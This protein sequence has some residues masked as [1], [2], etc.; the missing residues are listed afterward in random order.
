MPKETDETLLR[1]KLNTILSYGALSQSLAPNDSISEFQIL[2]FYGDA[3]LN[4][5]VSLFLMQTRRFM[6]PG[7]LT[8]LRSECVCN[9]NLARVYDKLR[10]GELMSEECHPKPSGVKDKADVMEA[11]IGELSESATKAELH[12]YHDEIDRTISALLNF[13]SY[14][15]ERSYTLQEAVEEA[16]KE[17]GVKEVFVP[18][19]KTPPKTPHQHNNKKHETPKNNKRHPS[20]QKSQKK[21][22]REARKKQNISLDPLLNGGSQ[23]DP[24]LLEE[25]PVS[26]N[27]PPPP[28]EK[29][30]KP[31]VSTEMNEMLI[32]PEDAIQM[33]ITSPEPTEMPKGASWEELCKWSKESP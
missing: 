13:I 26:D 3:V 4:Q 1:N 7:G 25:E 19:N 12:K 22:N 5:R 31:T 32:T 30:V 10:I 11:I 27:S 2:E 18:R 24:I 20:P 16:T 8:R 28:L 29:R 33:N 14:V 21:K 17:K 6:G 15:G 23:Y 9:V